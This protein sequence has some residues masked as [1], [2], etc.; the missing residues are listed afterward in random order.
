MTFFF[1]AVT[2]IFASGSDDECT[3]VTWIMKPDPCH[4]WNLCSI[5]LSCSLYTIYGE[6]DSNMVVHK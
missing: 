3:R 4:S 6:L 5:R 1:Y 2:W